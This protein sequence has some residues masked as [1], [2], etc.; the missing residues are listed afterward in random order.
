MSPTTPILRVLLVDDRELVNSG[1]PLFFRAFPDFTFTGKVSDIHAAIEYVTTQHLDVVVV[2]LKRPEVDAAHA[3]RLIRTA[4]PDVR[5]VVLANS[6]SQAL[7]REVTEAGADAVL[8]KDISIDALAASL[9]PNL[10]VI[11]QPAEA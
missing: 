11:S 2:D 10:E 5:I 7:M 1:L 3:V 6:A 4:A 8:T 9:R